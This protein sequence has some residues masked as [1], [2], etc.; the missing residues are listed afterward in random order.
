VLRGIDAAGKDG[1]IRHVLTGLNPQGCKVVSFREPTATDLA[2]DY[3]W[4]VHGVCPARGELGIF[5]RSHYEDV[6][7]ARVRGLVPA[8]IWKR[9]YEHIR[10]F[11]RL[12]HDEGTEVMKVFLH[13]SCDEQRERL[14]ERL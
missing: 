10:G 1:T 8:E 6:V 4:R 13:V 11:E 3:L 9:R 2:H 14:Q 12:L 7:A 5:N